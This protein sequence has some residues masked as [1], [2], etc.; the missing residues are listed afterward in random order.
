LSWG[1]FPLSGGLALHSA[2]YVGVRWLGGGW[3]DEGAEQPGL[4]GALEE[5]ELDIGGVGVGIG[6]DV[7]VVFGRGDCFDFAQ[8]L[9][10]LVR[11]ATG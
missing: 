3:R 10:E 5:G 4:D 1:W 6:S 8:R 9:D 7:W 11:Q 2:G